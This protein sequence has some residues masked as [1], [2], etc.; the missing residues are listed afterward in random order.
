MLRTDIPFAVRLAAREGWGIP[1]RD[2]EGIL[3]L[4]SQGSFIATNVTRRVGLAT[5]TRYGK[6]IGWIGNVVVGKQ[7]RHRHIGQ[8]LVERAIQH[9]SENRV[10]HIALYSFKDNF[11]FYKKLGFVQGPAFSRL[12]LERQPFTDIVTNKSPIKPLALSSMLSMDRKAFGADRSRL[13]N[14]LLNS[15]YGW[16]L[17]Y[18]AASSSSYLMVKKYED[19]YE[20]GPWVSF[21]LD[22]NELDSLLRI[23]LATARGKPVELSC[24]LSNRNISRFTKNQKFRKTNEGRVMFYERIGEIGQPKAIVAFGFLDKG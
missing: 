12:R 20:L 10:R 18:A 24:P 15:G 2:F 17:G 16:Y 6:Q 19:M 8:Q 11:Q 4:D 7:Y 14:L 13:L 21:G 23:A 22:P 5:T 1:A 3:R 9:L